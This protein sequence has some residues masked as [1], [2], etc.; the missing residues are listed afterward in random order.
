MNIIN[1]IDKKRKKIELTKEEIDFFI[2]GVIKNEIKDY[3]ISALLMAITINGMSE[4]ETFYLTDAMLRSGD[5]LDLSS[6]G[7]II[8]DKHSTGGVGD[9]TTLIVAPLVASLGVAVAKMSGRGLGHTGGTID[10]LESI[11]NFNVTMSLKKFI[12]QVQ[13]ID[14]ALVSQMAN[15]AYAD[16]IL[17]SIRDVTGTV[18]SIPLIASSIMSKKL[19]SGAD[20]IVI[21]VT[22]GSG[23]LMKDVETAR[24]LANL[25]IKIGKK[26][27]KEVVCVLSNM[28]Q[29]L[30][31]AIGNSLEVKEA[32]EML[33]GNKEPKDLYDLVI[34]VSSIMVSLGKNINLNEAKTLVKENLE[35]G[36]AYEKFKE[37][38]KE[39]KGV[40][41]KIK[42]DAKVFSLKSNETGFISKIDAYRLAECA[43]SLGAGR[44][45][46][47]DTIDYEVG[48]VLNKKKGDFVLKD[49]ELVRIYYK[50]KDLRINDVLSCFEISEH[51]VNYDDVI[52]EV[53]K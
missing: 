10:K 9:K 47:E 34:K 33:K 1:I 45:S 49:E 36:K 11:K 18:E 22:V 32:I 38:V 12:K 43:R 29:P 15:L 42:D 8:V 50:N 23:A 37:F 31:Y 52:I 41:T 46:K 24:E 35:N 14:L 39:Q 2:D 19:A 20:K 28:D 17:Y 21:D 6:I 7:K 25:M 13:K 48:I 30:G 53:I 3:Q 5:I 51:S 27:N 44:Y 40:I 26:Y 4:E 16:K